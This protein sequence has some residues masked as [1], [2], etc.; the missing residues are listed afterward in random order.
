MALGDQGKVMAGFAKAKAKNTNPKTLAKEMAKAVQA[1]GVKDYTEAKATEFIKNR[2]TKDAL[3]TELAGMEAVR[4]LVDSFHA[5]MKAADAR[6][7]PSLVRWL[8]G[9]IG[10]GS[11]GKGGRRLINVLA[12]LDSAD[13]IDAAIAAM[14][15][16]KKELAG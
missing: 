1:E 5:D 3:K 2:A 8:V 12:K 14:Q 15:A 10:T 9:E 4:T 16:R 7:T 11:T 6:I 13:A